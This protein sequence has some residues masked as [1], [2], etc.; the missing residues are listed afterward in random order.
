MND[1]NG[2][3]RAGGRPARGAGG[4][5]RVCRTRCRRRDARCGGAG[6][7]PLLPGKRTRLPRPIRQPTCAC[8]SSSRASPSLLQSAGPRGS[9]ASS[10]TRS[11][12]R[13]SSLRTAR[14]IDPIYVDTSSASSYAVGVSLVRKR[15]ALIAA[16]VFAAAGCGSGSSKTDGSAGNGAGGGGS[17]SGGTT[18]GLGGA[19]GAA[20]SGGTRERRR[21]DRPAPEA[22]LVSPGRPGTA[23]PAPREAPER[24]L[25]ARP[26]RF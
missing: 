22:S 23:E 7:V 1:G 12:I 2:S 5:A 3:V 6:I 13:A 14:A 17:G 26:D 8:A 19:G 25:A 21:P 9:R 24:E 15:R 11:R 18:A 4:D 10:A 20:G 16:F